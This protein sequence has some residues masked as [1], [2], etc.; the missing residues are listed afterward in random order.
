MTIIL[1]DELIRGVKVSKLFPD[2]ELNLFDHDDDNNIVEV[3][4]KG[5]WFMA[6]M[7]ICH[8]CILFH[9]LKIV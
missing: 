3:E 6:T 5:V 4:Y 9:Q 8:G 1:Y 2:F 7:G